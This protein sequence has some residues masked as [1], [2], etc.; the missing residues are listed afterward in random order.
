VKHFFQN[1]GYQPS[2]IIRSA[3][4][5]FDENVFEVRLPD[6]HGAVMLSGGI[7]VGLAAAPMNMLNEFPFRIDELDNTFSY[8]P[9]QVF[10][11]IERNQLSPAQD[12][13]PVAQGFRLFDVMCRV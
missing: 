2:S 13:H 8:A 4:R 1:T 9:F 12:S 7:R 3:P 5:Q 10:G 11:R 6:G